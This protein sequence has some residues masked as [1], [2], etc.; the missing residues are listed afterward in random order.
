MGLLLGALLLAPRPPAAEPPRLLREPLT[1]YTDS[2]HTAILSPDG[3]LVVRVSEGRLRVYALGQR[4][5]LFAAEHGD[6]LRRTAVAFSPDGKRIAFPGANGRVEIRVARTGKVEGSIALTGVDTL[7]FSP[8]GRRLAVSFGHLYHKNLRVFDTATGK[9][10]GEPITDVDGIAYQ[11][12]F[13]ADGKRLVANHWQ[14]IHLVDAV[15]LRRT[16]TVPAKAV[17]V[18]FQGERLYAIGQESG[19]IREVTPEGV[20]GEPI[21]RLGVKLDNSSVMR[22]AVSQRPAVIAVPRGNEVVVHSAEGRERFRVVREDTP[23]GNLSLSADGRM[24]LIYRWQTRRV[25]VFKLE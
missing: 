12:L 8:D 17:A 16:A 21:G 19:E 24:L 5:P 9:L 18:F 23:V 7:A 10:L 20:T 4:T 22:T 15:A 2:V 14:E 1:E 3:E 6:D 13:S 11:I 25:E